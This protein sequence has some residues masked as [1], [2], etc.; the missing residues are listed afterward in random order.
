[1]K[2]ERKKMEKEE[3]YEWKLTLKEVIVGGCMINLK[4]V[5][6]DPD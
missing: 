5:W 2:E 3:K 1:M 4:S 6:V